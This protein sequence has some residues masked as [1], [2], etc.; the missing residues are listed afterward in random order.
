MKTLFDRRCIVLFGPPPKPDTFDLDEPTAV[1]VEGLRVTFKIAKDLQSTPNTSE[2]TIY[3][4]ASA[5]RAK[6]EGKGQ[7][8]VLVAG[9]PGSEA[10][11][12]SGDIRRVTTAQQGPDRVTKIEAGDGERAIAFARVTDSYAPGTSLTDVVV[13]TVKKL[14]SDPAGAIQKAASFVGEFSSG[15]AQF[16]KASTELTRLLSPIGHTWSIQDGRVEILGE[17][18]SVADTAPLLS[19][20]TGLVGSPTFGTSEKKSG[21]ATMKCRSLLLP[22]LRPGQKV[23]LDS[24]TLRGQFRTTKVTHAGDTA[25][26]DWYSDIEATPT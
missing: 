26:N 8:I 19:P 1:R 6:L 16:G 15:Y 3:N 17:G 24:L 23:V 5:S 10:Q 9:Y 2:I 21:K 11:I 13:R 4:L 25:G 20:S 22:R 7:R 12:F 18:E 14:A